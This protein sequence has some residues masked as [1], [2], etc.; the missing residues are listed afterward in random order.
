MLR[1]APLFILSYLL[2]TGLSPNSQIL[3]NDIGIGV[4]SQSRPLRHGDPSIYRRR[5][6]TIELRFE[7]EWRHSIIAFA[8]PS[9]AVTWIA[10]SKPG[11]S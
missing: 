6:A 5:H 7:I 10:A 3:A 9:A 11:P 2:C 8:V 1:S 4:D